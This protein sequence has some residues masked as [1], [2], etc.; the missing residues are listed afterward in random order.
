M[1]INDKNSILGSNGHRVKNT[2]VQRLDQLLSDPSDTHIE[3]HSPLPA[4]GRNGEATKLLN[5]VRTNKA[6]LVV[7]Q[8]LKN[9]SQIQAAKAAKEEK[10]KQA[11]IEAA[12]KMNSARFNSLWFV[13]Q[14]RVHQSDS[15]GNIS[16]F[17]V[18]NVQ[19]IAK[20]VPANQLWF[21]TGVDLAQG[22][23]VKIKYTG[24]KWSVSP[25]DLNLTA[26]GTTR[27][28]GKPNYAL[29]GK[30]A[31]SLIGKIGNGSSFY[32]GKI[33]ELPVGQVGRLYLT[34]ND[35]QGAKF[36]AG[37]KD[38]SGSINI[39]IA[40][41]KQAVSIQA[42]DLMLDQSRDLIFWS[43][44]TAP[45]SLHKAKLDGSNYK[46]LVQHPDKP[47]TSVALD[48]INKYIYHIVGS[49][50]IMRVKYD[51][52]DHVSLIDISGPSKDGYWQLE[53]DPIGKKIYWTNDYSIWRANL[54]GGDVELVVS[55]HEAPFPI[56]I[57]VDGERK[58]LYWVDKDLE[59]V[60]RSNLDGSEPEDLHA[61]KNPIR[62][63][64]LDYVT[65]EMRDVLKQEVYWAAREENI[66]AQTPGIVGY[67]PLDK[68]EGDVINNNVDPFQHLSRG[69]VKTDADLPPNLSLPFYALNF[70]GGDYA[71]IPN[72]HIDDL[73]GSSFTV[74]LWIKPEMILAQGDMGLIAANTFATNKCLHLII[75]NGLAYL[76]FYN[77]DLTGFTQIEA[78]KW[79][80]LAFRYDVEK[81][82]QAI[83]VNGN[84]DARSTG[85][86][87]LDNEP[88]SLTLLGSYNNKGFS[89]LMADVR[90][91]PQALND[92]IIATTMQ[93]HKPGDLMDGIV[94]GPQWN[95]QATPPTLTRKE[96][97]LAFN[98]TSTYLKMGSAPTLG[99]YKKSFTVECWLQVDEARD[100]DLTI[101]GVDERAVNQGLHLVL[102]KGKPYMGFFNNDLAGKTEIK[103][104]EWHHVA[105]RF[106]VDKLEQS[107]HV[108]GRKEASRIAP[109]P[110]VGQGDV[111]LGRWS[112]GRIFSGNISELRIWEIARSDHEIASN[113][114]HYREFY[115][116]RGAVDAS[117]QP[118][119]L[120]DIPA[121]GGLNLVSQNKKEFEERLLAYRVRKENQKKAA[122][123]IQQAHT[124]KAHKVDAKS[125]ELQRTQQDT[126]AEIDQKKASHAQHRTE[127]RTKLQQAQNDKSRKIANAKN[128]AAQSRTQAESQAIDIKAKANDKSSTMKSKASANRERAQAEVN[129]N[130]R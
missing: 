25:Q 32:V 81:Q 29:P 95:H 79:T 70:T 28:N 75:R 8:Q 35:D 65:P 13:Y 93:E 39:D 61:V 4:S 54:D 22:E 73:R 6:Q 115:A 16:E 116:L 36:G 1:N 56:D 84:L 126:V 96:S 2:T 76:G 34:A 58:K 124:E 14:G 44:A 102:R 92:A 38:N 37:Y 125:Q 3:D 26:T 52:S 107:I 130:Q 57:A 23:T 71:K 119:H 109:N 111:Y 67:W 17:H 33:Y 15:Q 40:H 97:V 82:E 48:E 41:V 86:A 64:M 68:G 120:F 21:D 10:L 80:H 19:H 117:S 88:N 50:E 18:G 89:G 108:D 66:N 24:G 83:F 53:I 106:N 77:N 78:K 11:H 46:Q 62:G 127:N 47:V 55:N 90:I 85:H 123:D 20:A 9:N 51:G 43:Q 118:E 101:M 91:I 45:F 104:G 5:R 112:G 129:K 27:F 128:S 122:A 69:L 98:G 30:P 49:G 60:R 59:V 110:F 74:E 121:E 72:R 42:S 103:P 63:L 7:E 12:K 113:Y 100:S 105:W 99:L 94:S 114:R 87:P 31:G